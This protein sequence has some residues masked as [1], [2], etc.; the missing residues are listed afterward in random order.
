[1]FEQNYDRC[2]TCLS[3]VFITVANNAYK[4]FLSL[5]F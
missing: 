3:I 4:Y 5:G 1:M 2:N